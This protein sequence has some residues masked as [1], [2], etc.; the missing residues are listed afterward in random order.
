MKNWKTTVAG[1]AIGLTAGL[2]ALHVITAEQAGAVMA[3]LATF[4]LIA[5]KDSNVTGGTT[6]Q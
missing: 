4:G 2:A 5:A 1:I 3:A 6:K